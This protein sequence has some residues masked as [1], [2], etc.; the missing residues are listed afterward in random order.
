M[1]KSIDNSRHERTLLYDKYI[2]YLFIAAA[3]LMT[4]I[5]LAIVGAAWQLGWLDST[6]EQIDPS[7]IQHGNPLR[8]L[9]TLMVLI[10][11]LSLLATV[12]MFWAGT[13]GEAKRAPKLAAKQQ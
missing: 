11:G 5:I 9:T 10:G 1:G 13:I 7:A 4:L 3:M 6:L 12:V 8:P 2:R